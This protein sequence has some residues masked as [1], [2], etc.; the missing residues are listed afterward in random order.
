MVLPDMV[1]VRAQSMVPA[2]MLARISA[3][4]ALTAVPPSAV[5][6]SACEALEVRTRRP[7]TDSRPA[8]ADLQKRVC[9]G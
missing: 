6:K 1:P 4:G 7:F 8:N 5:T 9:A 2:R 3:K